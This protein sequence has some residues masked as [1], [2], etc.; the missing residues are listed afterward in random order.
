MTTWADLKIWLAELS[1][2]IATSELL[3]S[4]FVTALLGS[5]AGAAAGAWAG[6]YIAQRIAARASLREQLLNELRSTNAAISV[7]HAICEFALRLKT[8]GVQALKASFDRQK[9]AF[10]ELQER[11]RGDEVIQPNQFEIRADLQTITPFPMPSDVLQN[12]VFEKITLQGRP[13]QLTLQIPA[14]WHSLSEAII[15]R[16]QIISE[17][18][19]MYGLGNMPPHIYFGT[20]D[21]RGHVDA[22][23]STSIEAIYQQ[24]ED[25]IWFA[26]TLGED[27]QQHGQT[28]RTAFMSRFGR[29]SAPRVTKVDLTRAAER[30]LLPPDQNYADWINMFVALPPEPTRFSMVKAAVMHP[31][32]WTGCRLAIGW[33]WGIRNIRN[34]YFA[35]SLLTLWKRR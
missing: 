15:N 2:S 19:E 20:P 3:N 28:V 24:I 4:S 29:R 7:A 14:V 33:S 12:F 1:H 22:R 10:V 35:L 21:Q 27:L 17:F 30:E 25:C 34:T 5:L 16:N 26:K 31:I 8:S 13:H 9:A 23:Y 11:L 32:R 18:K 6:A